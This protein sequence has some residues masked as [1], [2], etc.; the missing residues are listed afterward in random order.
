M[1]NIF[2]RQELLDFHM[3]WA[4]VSEAMFIAQSTVGAVE[5]RALAKMR[6]VFEERNIKFEDLL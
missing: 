2:T 4:E 3:T 6:K 5:R 1:K